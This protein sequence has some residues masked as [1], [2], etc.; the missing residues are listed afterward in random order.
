MGAMTSSPPGMPELPPPF[1]AR[2]ERRRS[3]CLVA[4]YVLFG[5]GAFVVVAGLVAGYFFLQ[6]EEGQRLASAV[7]DS[8]EWVAEASK[9]PGTD[10][11]RA[12]GCGEAMVSTRARLVE[13]MS[14]LLPA[15]DADELAP[16][17]GSAAEEI[18]VACQLG[19][20]ASEVPSCEAVARAYAQAVDSPPA[21]FLVVVVQGG[22]EHCVGSYAPDGTLLEP[23]ESESGP[24][25]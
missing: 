6:S 1:D 19:F 7:R 8:A 23:E 13:M 9:A 24:T 16:P 22:T 10:A 4:L 2:P 17:E 5:V 15:S 14:R 20:F 18:V 25:S 3:G 11:L 12:A 21:Q